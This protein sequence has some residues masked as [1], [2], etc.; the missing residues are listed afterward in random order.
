MGEVS[1]PQR[2]SSAGINGKELEATELQSP[3]PSPLPQKKNKGKEKAHTPE[4]D[5][6]EIGKEM[7]EE[8]TRGLGDV[9]LEDDPEN[10]EEPVNKKPRKETGK[11]P[12]RPQKRKVVYQDRSRMPHP[13]ALFILHT[14][15]PPQQRPKVFDEGGGTDTLLWNIGD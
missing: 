5:D 3:Q 15:S 2:S 9:E 6:D 7:E 4:P 13:L 11:A 10:L 1:S 14:D 12:R 8:I